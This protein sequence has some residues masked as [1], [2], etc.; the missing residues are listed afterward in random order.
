MATPRMLRKLHLSGVTFAGGL[1]DLSGCNVLEEI[2][3]VVSLL[4]VS[5]V[6]C[7]ASHFFIHDRF[8]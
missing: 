4:H 1:P 5:M 8:A 7:R 2:I 3:L 6:L